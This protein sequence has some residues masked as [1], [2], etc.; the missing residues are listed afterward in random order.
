MSSF[1]QESENGDWETQDATEEILLWISIGSSALIFL[2]TLTTA[3][4]IFF[5]REKDQRPMF[6][7]V[8][9]GMLVGFCI[10]YVVYNFKILHSLDDCPGDE[11]GCHNWFANLLGTIENLFLLLY[12]WL[13]IAQYLSAALMLPVA[14]EGGKKSESA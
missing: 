1:C 10:F 6:V 13:F 9:L 7:M 14:L 8:Q 5:R 12:D 3:F 11:N 4:I 2:I